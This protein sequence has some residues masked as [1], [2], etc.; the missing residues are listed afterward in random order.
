MEQSEKKSKAEE[1]ERG[2]SK[3]IDEWQAFAKNL[4]TK[5]EQRAEESKNPREGVDIDQVDVA[6][7]NGVLCVTQ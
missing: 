5:A 1:E 3:S 4:M 6:R 2:A 7:E